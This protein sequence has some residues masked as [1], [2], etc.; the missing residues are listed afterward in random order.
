MLKVAV[1]DDYQDIF[2]QIIDVEKYKSKYD[3]QVFNE[4]LCVIRLV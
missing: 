3:F 1:L 4:K 2:R